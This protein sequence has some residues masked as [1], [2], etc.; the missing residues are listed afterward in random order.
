MGSPELP[1]FSTV[2]PVKTDRSDAPWRE[3]LLGPVRAGTWWATVHLVTGALLA[4]AGVCLL[5]LLVTAAMFLIT[6][7]LVLALLFA[8]VWVL[9][10]LHRERFAAF[11][12]TAVEPLPRVRPQGF[13]ERLMA[14]FADRN[15]WRQ[16]IFL[17]V[18]GVT[19]TASGLLVAG[20]WSVSFALLALFSVSLG[21]PDHLGHA[22]FLD[23]SDTRLEA[24]LLAGGVLLLFVAP[25]A[26]R[27]LTALDL[28]LARA[29]LA[30]DRAEEL[31]HRVEAL[32]ESRSAVV[33]AADA[34][35]RRIERD[36]HDG[37]QQR[38]VA[39]AMNLGMARAL[40]PGIPEIAE[41]HEE[42]KEVLAELRGFVRGLHPAVL[43]DRGLDAALSG[44]ASRSP[45]PVTLTVDLPERPSAATESLAN[46]A[47]H[48]R[49]ARAHVTVTRAGDR[50]RVVVGD[51]GVGGAHPG[52]GSGLRGLS[53]RV[54]SIDGTLT[55]HSPVGGPTTITAE[56]PCVS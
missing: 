32:A 24:A 26:A 3:V 9:A 51:D 35:R 18:A 52:K 34:E 8:S 15:T 39:L 2:A 12:G 29:L 13:R 25:C 36:L 42:A 45:V 4:A 50:V 48:A 38:L 7:P 16:L 10:R 47:T 17:L 54:E 19:E 56:L 53:Q 43:N 21:A 33:D 14:E 20:L 31:S 30:P 46:A 23:P 55:V 1:D 41:A 49:A 44:V 27:A 40:Y 28:A 6:L 11:L 5:G 22:D 37:T